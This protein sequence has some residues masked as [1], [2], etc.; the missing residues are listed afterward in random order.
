MATI[1]FIMYPEEGHLFTS[2][3]LAKKLKSRQHRVIY[4]GIP[5]SKESVCSQGFEFIP[6]LQAF[7]PQSRANKKTYQPRITG[8]T[9]II[10]TLKKQGDRLKNLYA[11]LFSKEIDRLL[12]SIEIDLLIVDSAL[13]FMALVGYRNGIPS[14]LLSVTLQERDLQIPP[15][16]KSLMPGDNIVDKLRIKF[17]WGWIFLRSFVLRK[18]LLLFGI[19]VDF[20]RVMKKLAQAAN[21][22]INKIKAITTLMPETGLPELILC[23]NEF[24]FPRRIPENIHYI[25]SSIINDG[26]DSSFPW[27]RIDDT[28]PLVFCT[29]GSQ[30]YMYRQNLQFFRTVI[31]TFGSRSEWNLIVSL[32]KGLSIDQFKNGYSNVTVV[33]WAPYARILSKASLMITHGGLGTI[34]HC[35]YYGVPMIVFPFMRDQPGNAARVTYHGLGLAGDIKKISEEYLNTLITKIERDPTFKKR[36]QIMAGKFREAEQ[37]EKGIRYIEMFSGTFEKR[38]YYITDKRAMKEIG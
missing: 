21:Y 22:P 17:S 24:D 4:L 15:L 23:P 32:G 3:G 12:G 31:E 33:N 20:A 2:F 10:R 18:S 30:S 13:P 34:K 9:D 5:D 26:I 28:K 38:P 8:I 14:I 16:T 19:D 36:S 11:Y 1:V 37:A 7:F 35:I 25:E 6:V 29:L 27:E